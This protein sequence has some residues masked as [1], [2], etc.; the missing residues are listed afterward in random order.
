MWWPDFKVCSFRKVLQLQLIL[1]ICG[2]HICKFNY[3]L[4]CVTPKSILM[5]LFLSLVDIVIHRAVKNISLLCTV[6]AKVE[7]G[8]ALLPCFSSHM[9]NKWPFCGTCIATFFIFHILGLFVGNF[10]V[11]NSPQASF[12]VLCLVFLSARGHHA[13]YREN[14]CVRKASFKTWHIVLLIIGSMLINESYV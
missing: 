8:H 12:K 11:W 13:P 1:I 6:P 10:V 3:L 7:Q 5:A 2:L 14:I 9:V 4:K